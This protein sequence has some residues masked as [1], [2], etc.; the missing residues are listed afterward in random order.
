MTISLAQKYNKQNTTE[1]EAY[2][3]QKA[4]YDANSGAGATSPTP[5]PAIAAPVGF[6][7]SDRQ[8]YS[9]VNS[10]L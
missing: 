1:K 9:N 5:A 2:A 6:I 7:V 4:I 3:A 10:K 8:E